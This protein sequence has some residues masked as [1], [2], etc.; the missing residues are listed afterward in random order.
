MAIKRHACANHPDRD[1][2]GVC[3][4]T[5]Q[6]MCS[7]CAT[8]HEGVL[9][10]RQ[11]LEAMRAARAKAQVG[12]SA[13]LRLTALLLALPMSLGMWWFFKLNIDGLIHLLKY[14]PNPPAP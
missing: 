8:L 12:N 4:V 5:R 3:V 14:T 7:E 13:A 9:H 2:L 1:A 6:P 11:A 10:S